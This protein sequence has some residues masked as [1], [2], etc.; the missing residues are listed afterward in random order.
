[1]QQNQVLLH[2]YEY[3][4][5]QDFSKSFSASN[6]DRRT[7]LTPLHCAAISVNCSEML[8]LLL[9]NIR[10]KCTDVMQY[11][12]AKD[13]EGW[14]PLLWAIS[15]YHFRNA[16]LLILQGNIPINKLH[17]EISYVLFLFEND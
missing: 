9:E 4:T 8:T 12:N 15:G 2:G 5:T 1:M 16:K 13:N 3:N 17:E 11:I 7:N 14:T 10:E 6:S